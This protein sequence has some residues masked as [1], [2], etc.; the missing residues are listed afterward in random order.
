MKKITIFTI[1]LAIVGSVFFASVASAAREITLPKGFEFTEKNMEH[2]FRTEIM[3]KAREKFPKISLRKFDKMRILAFD[4]SYDSGT[5]G[6]IYTYALEIKTEAIDNN[7]RND[8]TWLCY[9]YAGKKDDVILI[10]TTI[11]WAF[12][13]QP[14]LKYRKINR[15]YYKKYKNL[16]V[17]YV[18]AR[19][20]VPTASNALAQ[21]TGV[22]LHGVFGGDGP[23]DSDTF[24]IARALG[25]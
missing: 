24:S 8:I 10:K 21:A 13:D 15:D 17:G 1:I 7:T 11:A 16:Y 22:G 12:L 4:K 3:Q 5:G 6:D 18:N 2:Q 23:K 25:K 20:H 9:A 19:T 14:N